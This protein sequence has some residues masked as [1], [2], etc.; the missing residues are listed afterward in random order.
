MVVP[1][2]R[3]ALLMVIHRLLRCQNIMNYDEND[4]CS[5]A[6]DRG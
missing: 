5:R 2:L 6:Y 1:G 3:G 4:Y